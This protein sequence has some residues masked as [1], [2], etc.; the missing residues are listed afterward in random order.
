MMEKNE[1]GREKRLRDQEKERQ[2]KN[3]ESNVSFLSHRKII[4][5]KIREE[6]LTACEEYKTQLEE[7]KLKKEKEGLEDRIKS[8]RHR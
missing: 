8:E 4:E 5:D 2:K 3:K 1:K 6:T 7:I